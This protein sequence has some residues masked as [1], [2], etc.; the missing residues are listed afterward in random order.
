MIKVCKHEVRGVEPKYYPRDHFTGIPE[1]V[2]NEIAED[3][4]AEV[5]SEDDDEDDLM[6]SENF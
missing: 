1:E 4:Y 5:D 2:L 6:V 3:L